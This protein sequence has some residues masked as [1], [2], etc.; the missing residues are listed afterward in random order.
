M[1][2]VAA[3]TQDFPDWGTV[4]PDDDFW[5]LGGYRNPAL[6]FALP[7]Q[8]HLAP[9]PDGSPDFFLEFF[10][11]RN[12]AVADQVLYAMLHMG[13]EAGGELAT[14]QRRVAGRDAGAAVSPVPFTTGVTWRFECGD[15]R[16]AAA[17]G[18]DGPQRATIDARIDPATAQLIYAELDAGRATSAHVALECAVA[19]YLPRVQ[20][21]ALFD[22]HALLAG[23]AQHRSQS[24]SVPL[25]ELVT[26]LETPPGVRFEGSDPAATP[27]QRALALAGRL[28]HEFGRFGP[29]VPNPSLAEGA[30]VTLDAGKAAGPTRWDLS[31]PLL[32]ALPKL[33]AFDPFAP[34]VAAGARDKVTAFT[35]VGPL[36]EDRL[37]LCVAVG[38]G[39]PARICN[40][41]AIQATLCVDGA[42]SRSGSDESQVVTLYP[43]ERA[44]QT[45]A[46]KFKHGDEKPYRTRLTLVADDEVTE[47]PWR[48]GVGAYLYVS[49]ADLPLRLLRVDATAALLAQAHISVAL[50]GTDLTADLVAEAPTASFLLHPDAATRLTITATDPAGEVEPI[51]LDHLAGSVALDLG[52]FPQF[53][54]QSIDVTVR[55]PAGTRSVRYA[56]LGETTAEPAIVEFTPERPSG[57]FSYFAD[58]LFRNRYRYRRDDGADTAPWSDPQPPGVNLALTAE[59]ALPEGLPQHA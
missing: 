16:S 35:R 40:C 36:P 43:R 11:D 39:F 17:A 58:Q 21:T 26:F 57:T 14:L 10:S 53:G 20:S 50:P 32:V 6:F 42:H 12:A 51:R 18:W 9:R 54:P 33:I 46:L 38:G 37:T 15:T 49:P 8:A 5:L 44:T 56:F 1:S 19:G 3:P 59:S 29:D 4:E 27:H 2:A 45:V 52:S 28:V 30:H 25:D 48:D 55:F 22:P 47:L 13:V 7:R 41:D 23:V 31:T 34:I 24:A